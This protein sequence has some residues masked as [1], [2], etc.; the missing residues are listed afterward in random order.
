MKYFITKDGRIIDL[1][2]KQISSYEIIDDKRA[3]DEY[4]VDKGFIMVYYYDEDIGEHIEYD[5]K[6][7]RSMD[8]WYLKDIIKQAD[9]IE[10][11]CDRVVVKD[12]NNKEPRIYNPN[13]YNWKATAKTLFG[14]RKVEWV[15]FA[16]WTDKGLIYVAKMNDKGALE[17]LWAFGN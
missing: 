5:G 7:G 11:L 4:G 13:K 14:L 16:I 12:F 3:I 6:A 9:T 8:N 15:K 10:E 17:L 1:T 2:S